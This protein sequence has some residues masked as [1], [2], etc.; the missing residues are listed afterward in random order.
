MSDIKR[1]NVNS[2]KA[3]IN[4][5]YNAKLNHTDASL[6]TAD[7]LKHIAGYNPAKGIN[8]QNAVDVLAQKH[9]SL[10]SKAAYISNSYS[11]SDLDISDEK[12]N[13][14][15]RFS[16]GHFQTLN[17]DSSKDATEEER[18]LMSAT[19]KSKLNSIEEGAEVNDVITDDVEGVDLDISDENGNIL[20]Q[21]KDGHIKTKNFDSSKDA[22]TE[23]RGLMSTNDKVAL[24]ESVDKLSTVEE[25]AEVNDVN[26]SNQSVSDLDF[27]DEQDNVVMRLV[28]GHIKTKNFD[29]S[30]I[31]EKNLSEELLRT[32]SIG[33]VEEYKNRMKQAKFYSGNVSTLNLLHMSDIHG[34]TKAA[35]YFKSF[36]DKCSSFI[37]DLVMTGDVAF[38]LYDSTSD[39]STSAH[40][41]T[42]THGY[43]WWTEITKMAER[44]LFVLGNHDCQ[45][46]TSNPNGKGRDW[47]YETYFAPFA[48]ELGIVQ[49][50]GVDD[51]SS[52]NYHA[53]YWHK[54]Y[55]SPKIRIIGLDCMNR[56]D[57]TIDE[58]GNPVSDS[59][60]DNA[61]NDQELWLIERLAET[62]NIESDVY[63]YSVIFLCHYPLEDFSGR[64]EEWN[65][66]NHRFTYNHKPVGGCVMNEITNSPTVFHDKRTNAYTANARHHMHNRT[67]S[68][69]TKGAFNYIG[70]IIQEW[71]D[72]GGKYVAWI[73]G[74]THVDYMWY[75]T[76]Y[77][78][79]LNVVIDKA[80]YS[81]GSDIADREEGDARYCANYYSIDT[82]L[83]LFKIVRIGL[84]SNKYL[85]NKDILCY[86]YINKRVLNEN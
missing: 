26:T 25:G 8:M 58:N 43:K 9:S 76:A 62:L 70:D 35:D 17:F 59:W 45:T 52:P 53:C 66:T 16:E 61:R 49:P 63:G 44:C 31:K 73:C 14:L 21:A 47:A 24:D 68:R 40:G 46:D 79:L 3:T 19:D 65:E 38:Y 20:I 12:G 64:N 5:D 55:S 28:N 56:Y 39:T 2:N 11:D 34:D 13:V 74:H 32:L 36:A 1:I 77:P 41:V 69:F 23:E 6:F 37:D 72:D 54:D 75:P 29:S 15:A 48:D 51:S 42:A 30:A 67:T 50:N 81:R 57:G 22:T 33:G 80:G 82:D 85:D 27:S 84:N 60:V 10:E 71:V 18:G 78:T 7:A 86:D 83:G 4:P